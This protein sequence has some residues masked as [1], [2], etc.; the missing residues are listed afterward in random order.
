MTDKLPKL[1][2]RR[3]YKPKILVTSMAELPFVRLPEKKDTEAKGH[4]YVPSTDN[5]AQAVELGREYAAH[6]IQYLKDNPSMVGLNTLYNVVADMDFKTDFAA[7][8]YQEGFFSQLE[9]LIWAATGHVDAFKDVD[10]L[11]TFN[12]NE[13]AKYSNFEPGI[14]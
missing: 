14:A 7:R 11:R 8:G 13:D 9:R 5:H 1:P 12:A 6:L 2:A 10:Y 3:D 4:W